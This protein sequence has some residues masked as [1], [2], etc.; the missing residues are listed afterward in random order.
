MLM[1]STNSPDRLWAALRLSALLFSSGAFLGAILV[2][3]LILFPP[4]F[5]LNSV[6]FEI[7]L[8]P[9]W[10]TTKIF[11]VEGFGNAILCG[12]LGYGILGWGI[13]LS[14]WGIRQVS[15]AHPHP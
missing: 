6:I 10:I 13:G 5:L 1:S 15:H 4:M 12:A 8:W 9:I 2:P 14:V 7:L 3:F 11:K